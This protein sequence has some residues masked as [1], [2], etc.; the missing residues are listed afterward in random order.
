ML[1]VLANIFMIIW[2]SAYK[3]IVSFILQA[4]KSK[5][6][7]IIYFYIIYHLFVAFEVSII[8]IYFIA[9]FILIIKLQLNYEH[10]VF[11]SKVEH[12]RYQISSC[13]MSCFL[14][15]FGSTTLSISPGF[16][17]AGKQIQLWVQIFFFFFL[18]WK[19]TGIK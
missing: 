18:L 7:T 15:R 9:Q 8:P 12:A 11:F 4:L 19:R 5:L 2:L 13:S 1:P 16:C 3:H 14:S 6:S 10:C 17:K